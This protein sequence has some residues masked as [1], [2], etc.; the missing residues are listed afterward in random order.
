MVCVQDIVCRDQHRVNTRTHEGSQV[1][2]LAA[3]GDVDASK[4]RGRLDQDVAA[5]GR[6]VRIVEEVVEP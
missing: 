1:R 5:L 2:D 3:L 6:F 4:G